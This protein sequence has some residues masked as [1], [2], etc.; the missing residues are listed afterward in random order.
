M[1]G[2]MPTIKRKETTNHEFY[3]YKALFQKCECKLRQNY[4]QQICLPRKTK[5]L[6]RSIAK[7][8]NSNPVEEIDSVKTVSYKLL[9]VN[10]SMDVFML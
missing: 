9:D 2:C 7:P 8:D 3:V 4:C 5:R 10:N 1:G 6:F